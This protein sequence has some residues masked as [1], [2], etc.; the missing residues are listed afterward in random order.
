VTAAELPDVLTVEQLA[1]FLGLSERAFRERRARRD[2]PF[3][4]IPGFPTKG[5]SARYSKQ[6]VLDVINGQVARP[7]RISAA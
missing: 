6:H 4:P 1:A 7:R 5:K 3:S 2:W